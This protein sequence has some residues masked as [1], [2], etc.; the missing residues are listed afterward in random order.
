MHSA[1]SATITQAVA[2]A[3]T[4]TSGISKKSVPVAR[5]KVV[6]PDSPASATMSSS[7]TVRTPKSTGPFLSTTVVTPARG[8]F[9]SG[10]LVSPVWV[11][12]SPPEREVGR[13]RG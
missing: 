11:L 3:G 7:A 4:V 6:S 10:T 13:W 12:T 8:V 1:Q 2:A 9:S 5:R